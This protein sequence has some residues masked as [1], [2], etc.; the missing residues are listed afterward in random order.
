MRNWSKAI[1]SV[2]ICVALHS[3]PVAA[4]DKTATDPIADL[5]N[6]NSDTP[7]QGDYEQE[8]AMPVM[9]VQRPAFQSWDVMRQYPRYEEIAAPKV[10]KDEAAV[11]PKIKEQEKV[12][13]ESKIE[14]AEK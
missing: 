4:V 6:S 13:D 3:A 7:V 9:P 1:V 14:P 5:F 2:A 11:E 12:K 10:D 8:S